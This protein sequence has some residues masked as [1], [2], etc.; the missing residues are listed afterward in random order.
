MGVNLGLVFAAGFMPDHGKEHILCIGKFGFAILAG[1]LGLG[2]IGFNVGQCEL[3][4]IVMGL[5]QP[6][7]T[8][9]Q[10]K[11]ADRLGR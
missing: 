4:G 1:M 11:G 10:Y 6:L 3:D 5:Q 9:D 8:T 7:V 2:G